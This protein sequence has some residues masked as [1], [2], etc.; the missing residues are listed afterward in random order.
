MANVKLVT[1]L[2]VIFLMILGACT[3]LPQQGDIA[4]QAVGALTAQQK[5]NPDCS[6]FAL[7]PDECKV[8]RDAR[9]GSGL[10]STT[11]NL[12]QVTN[13]LS[14][15]ID[16]D[17]DGNLFTPDGDGVDSDAQWDTDPDG[18]PATSDAKYVARDYPPRAE[19]T[20]YLSGQEAAVAT[21]NGN[22]D[23]NDNYPTN[24]LKIQLGTVTPAANEVVFVNKVLWI[25]DR[26]QN[27]WVGAEWDV[28]AG[29]PTASPYIDNPT[30]TRKPGLSWIKIAGPG[31]VQNVPFPVGI[32]QTTLVAP[33]VQLTT[34][35]LILHEA[36]TRFNF[37]S[38]PGLVITN[39][40]GQQVFRNADYSMAVV[41]A[42]TC[43]DSALATN[44]KPCTNQRKWDCR[45]NPDINTGEPTGPVGVTSQF[46]AVPFQVAQGNVGEDIVDP[47]TGLG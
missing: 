3:Q 37:D 22:A 45:T 39:P 46:T 41:M 33:S 28:P 32:K 31:P 12:L 19:V 30:S 8:I 13:T 2:S 25:F 18:N 29:A 47:G 34:G 10:S 40:L 42:C 24:E 27:A 17:G 6:R 44:T 5:D 14:A 7:N 11:A 9:A 23:P 36:N 26:G 20:V 38:G 16:T 35:K 15:A 4:G 21:A 1:S 43:I